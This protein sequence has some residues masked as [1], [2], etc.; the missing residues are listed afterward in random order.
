MSL[1]KVLLVRGVVAIAAAVVV[2]GTCWIAP[3]YLGEIDSPRLVHLVLALEEAGT[4]TSGLQM[5]RLVLEPAFRFENGT[6]SY[7]GG[8]LSREDFM[9]HWTEADSL[10]GRFH[11]EHL[12][13]IKIGCVDPYTKKGWGTFMFEGTGMFDLKVQ[14]E[15]LK[16]WSTN[17]TLNV[18]DESLDLGQS[19][20]V[21]ADTV[22]AG[23]T[24][25]LMGTRY[26]SLL[27]GGYT[28]GGGTG[29][30][31]SEGTRWVCS[32]EKIAEALGDSEEA[33]IAF[34]SNIDIHAPYVITFNGRSTTGT[35]QHSKS[36]V[37]GTIKLSHIEGEVWIEYDFPIYQVLLVPRPPEK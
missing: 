7:G 16:H 6:I 22:T 3:P 23:I 36:L 20:F 33:T 25:D 9:R 11:A 29:Q 1:R 4:D 10:N 13:E 17:V 37:M 2:S 18:G 21:K 32:W 24:V 35:T 27:S 30:W 8:S 12:K 14:V 5:N 34:T 31:V 28:K 19:S 15:T 26:E